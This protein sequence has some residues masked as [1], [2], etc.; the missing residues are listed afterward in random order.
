MTVLD[1][2]AILAFLQ[3]EPGA[4]T[5]EDALVK[6]A[7]CSTANWSEVA[8]KLRQHGDEWPVAKAVLESYDLCREPVTVADAEAAA[9]WWRT[10]PNL[11]LGDRLCLALADR[12]DAE[13]LTADRMWDGAGPRVRLIR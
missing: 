11:S 12:L 9:L 8:Q 1:A 2:S 5:V 4:A 6:G 13:T 7:T 3:G 10:A